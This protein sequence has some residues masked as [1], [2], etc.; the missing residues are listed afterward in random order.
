MLR[1]REMCDEWIYVDFGV[2]GTGLRI[3]LS[4]CGICINIRYQHVVDIFAYDQEAGVGRRTSSTFC[5]C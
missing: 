5:R 3:D 1:R 2:A 4:D